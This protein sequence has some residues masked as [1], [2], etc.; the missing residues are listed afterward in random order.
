[1]GK[2]LFARTVEN[3]KYLTIHAFMNMLL[4]AQRIRSLDL[5]V[6]ARE[7]SSFLKRVLGNTSQCQLKYTCFHCSN[8]I[9]CI[10]SGNSYSCVLVELSCQGNLR[11]EGWVLPEAECKLSVTELYVEVLLESTPLEGRKGSRI[12]HMEKVTKGLQKS[13]CQDLRLSIQKECSSVRS[14][15]LPAQGSLRPCCR[16]FT[17]WICGIILMIL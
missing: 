14:Y 3:P 8:P 1:M 11:G 10:V 9:I 5:S 4:E 15:Q 2:V 13:Y 12:R 6:S 7:G 16:L 17:S